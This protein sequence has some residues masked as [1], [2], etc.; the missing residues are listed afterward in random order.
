MVLFATP[1]SAFKDWSF[2][3]T[4]DNSEPIDQVP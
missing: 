3:T 4:Q 2:C 1:L